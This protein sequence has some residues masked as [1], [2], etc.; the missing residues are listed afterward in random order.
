MAE[1]PLSPDGLIPRL[2]DGYA[3][4]GVAV[5]DGDADLELGDLSVEVPCHEPLAQQFHTMHLR[6]DAASAVVSAP[7]SPERAA[8]VFRC[9]QGLVSRHWL[10]R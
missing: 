3:E 4:R 7:S 10:Q 1:V 2:C 8:E 5:Q 6:L 9:A